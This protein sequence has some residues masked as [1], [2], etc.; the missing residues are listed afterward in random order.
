MH[1]NDNHVDRR[2]FLSLALQGTAL[3]CL[4]GCAG[5]G[6]RGETE[7]PGD[8]ASENR[9][10]NHGS[11]SKSKPAILKPPCDGCD[12]HEVAP[13][14]T[15]PR[16]AKMY[17][18]SEEAIY[19]A[20][21]LNPGQPLAPGMKLIIP[22]PTAYTNI[23][24]VFQNDI[25]KYIIIHHTAGE[26]GKALLIDQLHRKRGFEEGIGYDFLIDNGTVG[27][28]NGQLEVAPRWLKQEEG[29]HCKAGGMNLVGIGIGLVGN[30]DEGRPTPAQMR[31]LVKLVGSLGKYYRIA[32]KNIL[33]HSQVPGAHT[34]CPGKRFPWNDFNRSL[35]QFS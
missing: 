32:S 35:A 28:G 4:S 13:M 18:V 22:H 12:I 24:P 19:R 7:L 10:P 26:V 1:Y 30:F 29:A 2:Y 31:T 25:W 14:E 27:K 17:G 3:F 23:V 11:P 33:G 21:N 8:E 15:V 16:L 6:Y 34:D 5:P 20:N 9:R